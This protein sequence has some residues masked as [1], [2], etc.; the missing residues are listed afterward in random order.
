MALYYCV[1]AGPARCF[2]FSFQLSC[3]AKMLYRTPLSLRIL[4]LI[5]ERNIRGDSKMYALLLLLL[6]S[7]SGES[8]YRTV[9]TYPY[10]VM[11]RRLTAAGTEVEPHYVHQLNIT[12][13]VLIARAVCTW[14]ISTNSGSMEAGECGR[15]RGT[16]FITC[17]L[18]VVAVGGLLWLSWCVFGGADFL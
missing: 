10:S 4:I 9:Y 15:T 16:C 7:C 13:T 5:G 6:Q 11:H 12:S 17:R 14:P 3:L 18:E 2:L 8:T 1:I